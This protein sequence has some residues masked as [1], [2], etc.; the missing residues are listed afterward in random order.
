MLD[1]WATWCGPCVAALPEISAAAD[2]MKDKD[3]VF[4]TVNLREDPEA[5]KEFLKEQELD[6]PVLLDAE[7][8][9][10]D[11]YKAEAIPQTVLIGKDGR[12]QVVHVGFGGDAKKKL[13]EELTALLEGKELAQETLDKWEA[14]Q[15]K[16][17][18]EKEEDDSADSEDDDAEAEGA[19][20]EVEEA[21]VEVEQ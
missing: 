5:V 3:V 10:G 13:I 20:V 8:E 21:E 2:E 7:G 16:A 15:K 6:V 1:F 4:Y 12:V 9:I 11:L 19:D 18:A 17:K 14:D